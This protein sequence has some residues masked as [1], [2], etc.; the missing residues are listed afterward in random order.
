MDEKNAG[1][2]GEKKGFICREEKRPQLST[3]HGQSWHSMCKGY[4]NKS[5][6]SRNASLRKKERRPLSD[7]SQL[8]RRCIRTLWDPPTMSMCRDRPRK[9]Y[10]EGKRLH[11]QLERASGKGEPQ[12]KHHERETAKGRGQRVLMLQQRCKKNNTTREIRWNVCLVQHHQAD[13]K[14]RTF[15]A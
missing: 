10:W 12:E 8:R 5:L 2:E 7:L 13:G 9:K 14:K 4:K 1:V 6:I 15:A 3:V 11:L